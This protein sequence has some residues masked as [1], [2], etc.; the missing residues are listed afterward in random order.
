MRLRTLGRAARSS[1][2]G[3]GPQFGRVRPAFSEMTLPRLLPLL[4][5]SVLAGVV[6]TPVAAQN[7][8][9][10]STAP[11]SRYAGYPGSTPYSNSTTRIT[12]NCTGPVVDVPIAPDPYADVVIPLPQQPDPAFLGTLPPY[13]VPQAIIPSPPPGL[14]TPAPPGMITP[15][16]PQGY[17]NSYGFGSLVPP[18]GYGAGY[19]GYAAPYAPYG[20]PAAPYGYGY[21]GASPYGPGYGVPGYPPG[22]LPYP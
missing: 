11:G 17:Q 21:S 16:G 7:L 8:C 4:L 15:F 14:G 13:P 18:P 12:S 20:A 2:E 10:P 3:P 19:A 6:H 5:A 9:S 22:Y 1:G